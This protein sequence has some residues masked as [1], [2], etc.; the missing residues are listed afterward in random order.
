MAPTRILLIALPRMLEEIVSD[1]LRSERGMEI[2]GTAR[3]VDGL[4]TM[5]AR[6]RPDIVVLGGDDPTLAAELLELSPRLKVLAVADE[7][8]DSWLYGLRPERTRLGGLSPTRLAWAVQHAAA[9]HGAS[10]WWD[11]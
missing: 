5:V 11:R 3:N 2:A 6:A 9:P 8:Q 1:A 7:G 4:S 10:V